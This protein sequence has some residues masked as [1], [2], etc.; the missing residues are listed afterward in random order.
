MK[1]K[2]VVLGAGFG[3]LEISTILSETFGANVDV[4]LIDRNDAFVFGYSKLDVLFGLKKIEDVRLPYKNF[5][6]PGVRFLRRNVTS[7]DPRKK[8]VATDVESFEA[9]YLVIALG[10]EYDLEATPGLKEHGDEFYSVAGARR[11]GQIL[12]QFSKGDVVIGV[13]GAPYKC[14]PAPSE[15][16]LMMHD[17]LLQRGV[18][19]H[20]A[21]TIVLPF[22]NPIPPSPETSRALIDAF[23]E[24]NIRLIKG[25]EVAAVKK[26]AVVLNDGNELPFDLFMG[27][28]KHRGLQILKDC[29]LA[30][31]EGWIPVDPRTLA[32]K[33][34]RVYAVGDIAD[35]G[36]PMAGV[37]AE[38]G[39]RAVAK[40]LIAA[41]Q[42]DGSPGLYNGVGICYIEFGAGRIGRVEVDFFSGPKPTG[43]FQEPSVG[44][45]AEKANFGSSRRARWFGM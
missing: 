24:R 38:G 27:V 36:T 6:K 39:A 4:T 37:F 30:D 25:R 11:L 21:M 12:S 28:P 40:S 9:D 34:A 31:D 16:A 10:V 14:P 33:F 26:G 3:G 5:A 43:T 32:T 1:P 41:I 20:C 44:L 18:R 45:M 7:I 22:E 13:C 23:A 29:G 35:T 42:G 19:S 15:A 8:R 17:Y 2:V